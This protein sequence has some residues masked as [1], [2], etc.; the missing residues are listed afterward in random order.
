M[1][2]YLSEMRS[3][4]DNEKRAI[5]QELERRMKSIQEEID[6]KGLVRFLAEMRISSLSGKIMIY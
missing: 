1:G 5:D 3:N 6:K 4:A 2:H